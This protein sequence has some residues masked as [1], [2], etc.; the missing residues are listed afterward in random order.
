MDELMKVLRKLKL[1]GM[2]NVLEV[3]NTYAIEKQMSYIDFL[4]L[5]VEDEC[6]S[7][8]SNSYHKRFVISKLDADKTM[9]GYTFNFQPKLNKKEVLDVASCRFIH[10][11][12]NIVFM[13]NSGVGKTHLANAIGLEA[14]KQGFKVLMIHSTQLIDELVSARGNGTY[15]RIFK[16][17]LNVDV[18]II[19][20]LGFRAFHRESV[21]EFFEIV[22]RR[23]EVNSIIITSNRNFEDWAN[24]FG[25]KVLAS[26]IVDRVVHHSHIFRIIGPSYRTKNLIQKKETDGK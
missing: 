19:D 5:L 22:R 23:Y 24:I 17:F 13:G 26:A 3:R 1:S 8:Q 10:E 4:S 16:R 11:R 12:K 6:V 2:A 7:R 9:A 20:E 25:D 21:D 14:L 18:L 15:P